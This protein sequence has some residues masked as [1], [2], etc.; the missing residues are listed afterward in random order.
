M[1]KDATSNAERDRKHAVATADRHVAAWRAIVDHAV[2]GIVTIDSQGRV[3]TL[4]DAAE[5]MFGYSREELIG[6]NAKVLM[7]EPF[8]SKHDDQLRPARSSPSGCRSR[9]LTPVK[10]AVLTFRSAELQ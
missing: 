3:E 4:N 1:I 2:E 10:P 7:P 9:P 8:H 6:T 5:A